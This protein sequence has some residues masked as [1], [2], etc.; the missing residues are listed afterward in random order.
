MRAKIQKWGNSLALRIPKGYAQDAKLENN[1]EVDI[2]LEDKQ[3]VIKPVVLQ[4]KSLEELLAGVNKSNIHNEV[5]TGSAQ[6][7]EIW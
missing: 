3:I 6:G 5:K 2:H 1:S 4:N 7:N